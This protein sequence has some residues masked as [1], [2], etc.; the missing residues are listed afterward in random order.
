MNVLYDLIVPPQCTKMDPQIRLGI[1]VG[2]PNNRGRKW[3]A[4]KVIHVMNYYEYIE[5]LVR[6]MT[7][8]KHNRQF[9]SKDKT[10]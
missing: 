1:C 10:P 8:I 4:E 7:C 2:D 6:A 5:I 9:G 3:A